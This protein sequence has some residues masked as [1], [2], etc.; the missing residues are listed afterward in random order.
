M[1]DLARLEA[2]VGEY[3]LRKEGKSKPRGE[4]VSTFSPAYWMPS[5]EE[6]CPL[7]GRIAGP[8]KGGSQWAYWSHC[9]GIPH[10]AALFGVA[11]KDMRRA[12]KAR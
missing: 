6:A 7:C 11:E 3:L 12:L 8:Q 9:R 2:A 1:D 5:T 10:V 4:M